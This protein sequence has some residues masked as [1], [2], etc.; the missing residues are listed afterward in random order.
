MEEYRSEG[1]RQA[2][3]IRS[4]AKKKVSDLL[5][6]AKAEATILR[7]QADVEADLLRNRA[8]T[9]DPEFFVFLKKLE[10]MQSILG[11]NKTML[12]LSTHRAIFDSLFSPPRP[13]LTNPGLPQ[14]VPE[15]TNLNK[16]EGGL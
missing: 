4:N 8:H 14:R 16:K 12:L 1:K 11:E 2:E 7:G 5:A 3:N 10:K 6:Q 9:Q 13:V 15:P